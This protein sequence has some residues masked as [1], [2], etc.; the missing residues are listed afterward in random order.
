M[1]SVDWLCC[2][3]REGS[4]QARQTASSGRGTSHIHQRSKGTLLHLRSRNPK[5]H[6]LVEEDAEEVDEIHEERILSC[7]KTGAIIRE[8]RDRVVSLV[9]DRTGRF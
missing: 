5:D 7:Q 8:G 2:Q 4:S 6:P 1:R 3:M 9:T